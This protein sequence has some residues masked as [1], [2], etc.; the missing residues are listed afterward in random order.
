MTHSIGGDEDCSA[1]KQVVA[2]IDDADERPRATSAWSLG[3]LA[4]WGTLRALQ[5]TLRKRATRE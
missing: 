1:G 3:R 2:F 4:E 5:M